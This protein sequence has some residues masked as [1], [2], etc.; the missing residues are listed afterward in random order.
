MS[1]HR[2]PPAATVPRA[3]SSIRRRARHLRAVRRRRSGALVCLLGVGAIALIASWPRGAPRA[4]QLAAVVASVHHTAHPRAAAAPPRRAVRRAAAA[5][6]IL[7]YHVIAPPPPGAPYPGLYVPRVEFAAQ[8]HGARRRR[9]PRG[10]AERGSALL[11]RGHAAAA[12]NRSCSASTTA[13]ASQYR[14]ALPVLRRLGWVGDENLQLSGLPP[15]QGGLTQRRGSR[16][17]PAGWELDTQGCSHADLID[18][19]AGELA[20]RSPSRAR[21]SARRYHVKPTGSAT[22]RV[23]MT[24]WSSRRSRRQDS[25]A[26]PRCRRLGERGDDAYRLPRLRVLGGT[27]PAALLSLIGDTRDDPAPPSSYLTG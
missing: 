14:V 16:P 3:S 27:T 24:R 18:L 13:T 17:G 9:L 1:A 21:R 20:S 7:M 15:S 12:A 26:R 25:W 11:A 6:P 2:P 5:V 23:Y 4:R 8:M 22:P 19:D 10:D